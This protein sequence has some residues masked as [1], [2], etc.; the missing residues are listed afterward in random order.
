MKHF[1]AIPALLLTTSVVM[2]QE[3]P[4]RQ[5]VSRAVTAGAVSEQKAVE[6]LVAQN[7]VERGATAHYVA[8]QS[9]TLQPGFTAQAGSVFQATV[10]AVTSRP[11]SAEGSLSAT[12][13]PNPFDNVTSIQYKLPMGSKVQQ[14]LFDEKGH[15]VRQLTGTDVQAAGTYKT[16]VDGQNLPTGTY[17]YRLQTDTGSQTIRLLKK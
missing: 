3:Y 7:R 11:T 8:G 17:I 12:A 9:V 4:T 13:Y 1:L 6:H 16:Q 2:A 10:A 15:V 14:T 5:E